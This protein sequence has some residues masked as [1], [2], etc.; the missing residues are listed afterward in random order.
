MIRKGLSVAVIVAVGLVTPAW[1]QHHYMRA[2]FIDVGQGDATLLEF[3]CAAVMIDAGTQHP[4][5]NTR[6]VNYMES[7]FNRR[8]DLNRTIHTLFVTHTHIDHN[9]ALRW[10][11]KER[12]DST[13]SGSRF[14]VDY[15]VHNDVAR[16]SGRGPAGWMLTN[17]GNWSIVPDSVLDSEVVATANGLQGV[18]IDPPACQDIDPEIRVL[19]GR[20]EDNP[21]WSSEAWK[22]GSGNNQSLVI[23]VDFG[24]ASFLFTGD[25]EEEAIDTLV[26]YYDGTDLLDVD[27]YQVGHHGSHNGT[28]RRLIDAMSPLVAVISMGRWND[29]GMWTAWAYGHPRETAVDLLSSG[30]SRSR[31]A[32]WVRVA[33]GTRTFKRERMTRAVYATGWDGTVIVHA[34]SDGRLIVRREH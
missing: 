23:R 22:D 19:S 1:A 16:G 18:S 15:Y 14:A 17:A 12:P 3:P 26:D 10:L 13:T 20:L 30:I 28:T 7:F 27:V 29:Q 5:R 21:G 31:P 2:H 6:L 4:S 24:D 33:E 11:I 8:S 25:L 9:R 32:K 34:R